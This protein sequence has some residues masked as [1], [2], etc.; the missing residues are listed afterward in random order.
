MALLQILIGLGLVVVAFRGHRLGELRAGSAG[1]KPY[2]PSRRD[3]PLAFHFFLVL[4][5]CAGF[6]LLVWGVFALLGIA[7]PMPID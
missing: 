1:F 4:Y 2:T 3:N 5:L 6:A 7:K